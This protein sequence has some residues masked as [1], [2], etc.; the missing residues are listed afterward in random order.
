[1]PH[2]Q[3]GKPPVR[4]AATMAV[5]V[6]LAV[7]L[8]YLA[9]QLYTIFHRSYKTET[10]IA[11]TM[12]D[13]VELTGV[14]VFDGVDVPG[15]GNLGYLVRDGERVTGGT[16][17]AEHYTDT[18]QALLRE[19]LDT[20]ERSIAL[21]I[22]SQNST[23]SELSVLTSQ[24]RTALYDL[25]ECMDTSRYDG[26]TDAQE[27]FLLAQNRLQI[28]TGQAENFD[29]VVANLQGERSAIESQLGELDTVTASTNGYFVCAELAP[30]MEPE[31]ESLDA[32]SP[33]ELQAMLD[34]GF[35]A[36]DAGRAGRIVTGFS[37]RFYVACPIETAERFQQGNTV[38]ISVPGKQND[39]LNA[40][41]ESI[42]K[43]EETG[44]AKL[45]FEC[46]TINAQVL[47]LGV[48]NA[49]IDLKTYEGIRIDK[50]A[51]HIVNGEK[52]VYVKYGNLQKFLR[53]TVLYEND[54]YLLVPKN[55]AP[56]TEN[57]VR[58][59]DE[60]IVDGTNLRDGQLL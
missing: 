17:V 39:P 19:R 36:A 42:T 54:T 6:L 13:S 25:L 49:R 20:L 7:V 4:R 9:I 14:A 12:A 33:M 55:G 48:E 22:K 3:Q 15:G 31:Q 38:Q 32:A 23:G 44:L 57:E 27:N 37:W 11:Y 46:Q 47:R 2:S 30:S 29:A 21:L 60:V 26:I 34:A 35:P 52:G 18:N 59:Y 43:D 56:N 45:V 24:T 41:V 40:T 10:A 5:T 8:F 50:N 28:S 53:I 1:M 58:L 16:V 51:M